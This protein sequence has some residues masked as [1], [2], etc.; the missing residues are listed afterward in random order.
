MK[1]ASESK[2][3]KSFKDVKYKWWK[4]YA[5]PFC[6]IG[7]LILI[8]LAALKMSWGAAQGMLETSNDN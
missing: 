8:P 1:T 5:S 3:T 4:L 7:L 2:T 6:I